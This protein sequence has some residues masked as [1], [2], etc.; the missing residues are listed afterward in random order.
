MLEDVAQIR[1]Q[2]GEIGFNNLHIFMLNQSLLEIDNAL[3]SFVLNFRD[4]VPHGFG[5]E[6]EDHPSEV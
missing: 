1:K 2:R 5:N 4:S 6:L 3:N